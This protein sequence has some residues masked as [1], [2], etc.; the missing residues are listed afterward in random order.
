[1]TDPSTVLILATLTSA[2]L[3]FSFALP[4]RQRFI[5]TL[6]SSVPQVFS[7]AVVGIYPPATLLLGLAI[8]PEVFR[9]RQVLL[10]PPMLCFLA[11]L[12]VHVLSL[13]WS[14]NV[15][16]GLRNIIYLLPF[17]LMFVVSYGL[18]LHT[19]RTVY[20]ALCVFILVASGEAALVYLFRILPSVE[21]AFLHSPLARLFISPN[22]LDLLFDEARNNAL[23]P[24]KSGGIFTN[25]NVAACYLGV[26]AFIAW[27]VSAAC[28]LRSLFYF[29]PPMLGA[30]FF[31]G[32]KAG[33]I[34]CVL[35]TGAFYLLQRIFLQRLTFT[36]LVAV[37]GMTIV[38]VAGA[39]AALS[40]L[41][42]SE[43]AH[44]SQDTFDSR[45]MI[46][47]H[48]GM[49]FT[50]N[51]LWGQGFGGWEKSFVAYAAGKGLSEGFPP[52]NTFVCLWSQSGIAAVIMGALFMLSVLWFCIRAIRVPDLEVRAL[53]IGTLTAYLWTFLQGMGENWG[54]VGELHMQPPLAVV[55]GLSYGRYCAFT[56]T[57][58]PR[59]A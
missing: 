26:C 41:S 22:L 50:A 23:D 54:I 15:V 42:G 2:F 1:M 48:A 20:R 11:L 16:L 12:L 43:F 14:P 53:G 49:Q 29:A 51:P 18:T 28:R 47:L 7:V 17:V 39:L 21:E 44:S 36:N 55:L 37:C 59:G 56:A 19:P 31:T 6:W 46:W 52:H 57:S 8:W 32:S 4:P 27:G 40:Y 25:A 24:A 38:G 13:T 33:A 35:L 34:L 9:W 10:W 45:N 30:V 58:R 3:V 5:L